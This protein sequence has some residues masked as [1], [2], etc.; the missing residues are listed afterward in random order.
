[1]KSWGISKAK[2]GCGRSMCKFLEMVSCEMYEVFLTIQSYKWTIVVTIVFI[3]VLLN[4]FI[5]NWLNITESGTNLDFL[6]FSF[7][8]CDVGESN[9]I[10]HN[11][12]S[13][14]EYLS[15]FSED[16]REFIH[17]R[18]DESF[19]SAE[20]ERRCKDT[21]GHEGKLKMA[22]KDE[23]HSFCCNLIFLLFL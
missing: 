23:Q 6:G 5:I 22:S 17:Q 9:D 7:Y 18:G 1:M 11:A 4:C 19:H 16:V 3:I 13:S 8:L 15:A 10:G 2:S 21:S 12:N 20:L 14:N